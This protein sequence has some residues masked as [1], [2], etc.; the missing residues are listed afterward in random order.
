MEGFI[1][2][3]CGVSLGVRAS[4]ASLEKQRAGGRETSKHDTAGHVVAE[5][6]EDIGR[7]HPA[8]LRAHEQARERE[9]EERRKTGRREEDDAD[10]SLPALEASYRA[11]D[12][13]GDG[14][15]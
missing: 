7:H 1:A 2:A 4:T 3:R 14:G 12:E 5:E 9:Y 10:V 15:R 13:E 6:R 8:K 11:A